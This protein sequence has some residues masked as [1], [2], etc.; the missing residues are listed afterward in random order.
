MK[1]EEYIKIKLSRKGRLCLSLILCAICIIAVTAILVPRYIYLQ[2]Q[3]QSSQAEQV[4]EP[5]T[6][7]TY[8]YQVLQNSDTSKVLVLLSS[9]ND[10]YYQTFHQ[11]L[12]STDVVD[13]TKLNINDTSFAQME[14]YS[15]TMWQEYQTNFVDAGIEFS[16][17]NIV[18]NNVFTTYPNQ[19]NNLL[20]SLLKN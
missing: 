10:F 16:E 9:I 18:E 12:D 3:K 15:S 7:P 13:S 6:S 14:Q 17:E 2:N 8:S 1:D 4:Q 11:Y 20:S 19:L 5:D